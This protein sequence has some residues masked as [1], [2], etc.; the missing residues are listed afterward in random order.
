[1]PYKVFDHAPGSGKIPSA[2]PK[3]IS[4]DTAT[5]NY[6][7]RLLDF[8]KTVDVAIVSGRAGSEASTGKCAC[9]NV[10]VV[11]YALVLSDLFPL[12]SDFCCA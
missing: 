12:I 1:M 5:N 4:Q 3:K 10:S 9:K 6:G 11:A 8:C 7:F 2:L